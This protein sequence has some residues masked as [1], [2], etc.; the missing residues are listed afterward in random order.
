MP[1][2]VSAGPAL[3]T[4]KVPASGI[5]APLARRIAAGRADA[6]LGRDPEFIRRS[7]PA[8]A[9]YTRYFSPE[10]RGC[11][12]LPAAG[13]VLVVGNHSCLFYMPEVWVAGQAIAERRGIERP[14]DLLAHD[15]LFGVP[16]IG[17]CLRRLGAIPA[18]GGA[19]RSALAGGAAVL[20]YPGGDWEAC[21]PWTQ[22]DKVDFCGR[23]GFVRLALRCGVPVVPVVAHGGHHAVVV[24]TRGERFARAVGLPGIRINVFPFLVGPPFGMTPVVFPPPPM[25]AQITVEF[26]P[27]LDWTRHGAGAADDGDVV[28]ACYDEITALMQSALDRLRAERPHPLLTGCSRLTARVTANAVKALPVPGHFPVPRL[29]GSVPRLIGSVPG[30]I[31]SR[32]TASGSPI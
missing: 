26:L 24:L 17:T 11:E 7:L 22:R 14:L 12:R 16:A 32:G 4:R 30:L 29:I 10:V 18:G 19:A 31:G 8:V 13:P 5:V 28:G 27:A 25:P 6:T 3:D 1:A 2:I 9:G 20:V 21:R 23:N 15:F